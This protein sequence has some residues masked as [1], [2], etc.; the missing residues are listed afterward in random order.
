MF[1]VKQ[2]AQDQLLWAERLTDSNLWSISSLETGLCVQ[3][4]FLPLNNCQPD[5]QW[6]LGSLVAAEGA[7]EVY[8]LRG[9]PPGIQKNLPEQQMVWVK[10]ENHV[11]LLNIWSML[12]YMEDSALQAFLLDVLSDDQLMLPFC[13]ARASRSYH[14][15]QQGGLLAIAARWRCVRL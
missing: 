9:L 4:D 6:V 1:P 5:G 11:F 14:H 10:P 15:N 2:W 8:N 7:W 12:A 13:T 3:L